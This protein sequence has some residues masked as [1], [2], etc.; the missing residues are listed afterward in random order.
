MFTHFTEFLLRLYAYFNSFGTSSKLI[1]KSAAQARDTENRNL[2][3]VSSI[4]SQGLENVSILSLLQQNLKIASW[5]GI[6][7]TQKNSVSPLKLQI[8]GYGTP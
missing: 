1:T 3:F 6:V 2:T 7:L 4:Q 5:V 8:N